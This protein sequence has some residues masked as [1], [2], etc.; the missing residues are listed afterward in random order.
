MIYSTRKSA[1]SNRHHG[2]RV[3]PV[4]STLKRCD[5]G[6]FCVRV[7]RYLAGYSLVLR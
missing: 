2:E 4:Y 3:V 1:K 7:S 6:C 5:L